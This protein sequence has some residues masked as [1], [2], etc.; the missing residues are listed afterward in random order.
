MLEVC[1]IMSEAGA[2][3]SPHSQ[4]SPR[5][6]QEWRS[7]HRLY[8]MRPRM[9][10]VLHQAESSG[11]RSLILIRCVLAEENIVVRFTPSEHGVDY[12][13]Q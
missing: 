9:S 3:E 7:M 12:G 4:P 1:G 8:E 6:G 10:G 2:R 11:R 13:E 5:A